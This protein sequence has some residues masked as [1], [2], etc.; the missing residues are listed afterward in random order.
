[1]DLSE[2]Q[3]DFG[4]KGKVDPVVSSPFRGD[5]FDETS[6]TRVTKL[7]EPNPLVRSVRTQKAPTVRGAANPNHPFKQAIRVPVL[8][9]GL[10]TVKEKRS[11]EGGPGTTSPFQSPGSL[12]S[13]KVTLLVCYSNRVVKHASDLCSCVASLVTICLDYRTSV[14]LDEALRILHSL[15]HFKSV[16]N[17]RSRKFCRW[18]PSLSLTGA[19][20]HGCPSPGVL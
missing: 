11:L 7:P 9:R 13:S 6:E 5:F 14:G 12:R 17:H 20:R 15:I 2:K 1:M 8:V 4:S 3:R 19:I 18:L 10:R 16:H